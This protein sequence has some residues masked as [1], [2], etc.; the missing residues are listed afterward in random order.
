MKLCILDTEVLGLEAKLFIGKTS[1]EHMQINVTIYYYDYLF[2][3]S[4]H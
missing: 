3:L 2:Q 4:S 1:T